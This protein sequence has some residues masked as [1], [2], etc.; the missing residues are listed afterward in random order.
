METFKVFGKLKHKELSFGFNNVR[1]VN[2][3]EERL[4]RSA[5]GSLEKQRIR[6]LMSIQNEV[7]DLHISLKE[8]NNVFHGDR[9]LVHDQVE[10]QAHK[11]QT[12]IINEK[13]AE[14][15]EM[16]EKQSSIKENLERTSM[17]Q[18]GIV[19]YLNKTFL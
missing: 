9:H 4:L 7:E 1:G 14:R 2:K 15:V 12:P 17:N 6:S 8:T 18:K 19:L 3:R 10:I 11:C 5:L 16:I 13:T